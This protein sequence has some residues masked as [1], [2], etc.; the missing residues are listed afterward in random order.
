MFEDAI[1]HPCQFRIASINTSEVTLSI[2]DFNVNGII[3]GGGLF[4]EL[5]TVSQ[6]F[7]ASRIPKLLP[8]IFDK[9]L[10]FR[11]FHILH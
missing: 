9:F 8:C 3:E 6:Y 7:F 11:R 2:G 5:K 1:N 10:R 4:E